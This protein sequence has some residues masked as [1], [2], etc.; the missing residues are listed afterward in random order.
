MTEV[1]S[2]KIIMTKTNQKKIV[3]WSFFVLSLF[4]HKK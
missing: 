2:G 3:Q 4:G 1:E